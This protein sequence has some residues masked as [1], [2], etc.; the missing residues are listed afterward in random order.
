M[1]KNQLKPMEGDTTVH[2][3]AVTFPTG[4]SLMSKAIYGLVAL[5]KQLNNRPEKTIA[6]KTAALIQEEMATLNT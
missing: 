6:F 1:Q 4:V 3:N 5:A 2:P